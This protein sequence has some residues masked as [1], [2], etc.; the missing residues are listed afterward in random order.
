VVGD[1]GQVTV[2]AAAVPKVAVE[3]GG[4]VAQAE[5]QQQSASDIHRITYW[6]ANSGGLARQEMTR[7]T[8]D[9]DASAMPPYV[10]DE[11]KYILATEVTGL[12]FRYFDGTTW[13]DSWDGS[14][15]GADGKT[16]IGPPRLIEITLTLRHAG[17]QGGAATE[18]TFRHCVAIGAANAQPTQAG[19]D[20]GTTG[21][22][23]T[24]STTG[25]TP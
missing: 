24:S 11:S 3:A 8:A 6:L 12:A 15:L 9:D 5:Q 16:P 22:T 18:K 1:A 10:D 17:T 13:T 14:T 20:T 2:Y 21:S 25:G 19:S 23:G 7:V 4:D